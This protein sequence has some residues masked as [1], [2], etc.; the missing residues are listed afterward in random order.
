[1]GGSGGVRRFAPGGP[2][3]LGLRPLPLCAAPQAVRSRWNALP[4]GPASSRQALARGVGLLKDVA[5]Q[6]AH[7]VTDG[8]H[9]V[10][11][12]FE[13]V[14]D[15]VR[16]RHAKVVGNAADVLCERVRH[17]SVQDTRSLRR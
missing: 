13:H 7:V 14:A 9:H 1:M 11:D 12:L 4:G 8:L 15:Q 10:E 5:K 17:T 2:R 3:A 6:I 16:R